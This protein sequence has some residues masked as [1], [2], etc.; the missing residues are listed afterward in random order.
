MALLGFRLNIYKVNV[1]NTAILLHKVYN[2]TAPATF[3]ELFQKVFYLYIFIYLYFNFDNL[4][5]LLKNDK[6]AIHNSLYANSCQP[7]EYKLTGYIYHIN[8]NKR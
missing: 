2:G 8:I 3:F 5:L 6:V 7:Q 4:Q 1:L